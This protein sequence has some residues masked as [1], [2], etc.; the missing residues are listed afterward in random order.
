[1]AKKLSYEEEAK[2]IEAEEKKLSD[3]RARLRELEQSERNDL[4][5]KSPLA[6]ASLPDLKTL[7]DLVKKIGFAES[8]KRLKN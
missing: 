4:L 1:M 6:K 8:L 7:L 5:L 2:A 3:R